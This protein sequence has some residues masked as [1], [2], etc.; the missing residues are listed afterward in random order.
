M[1]MIKKLWKYCV[2]N[3]AVFMLFPVVARDYGGANLV[4]ALIPARDYSNELSI[5]VLALPSFVLMI[6]IIYGVRKAFDWACPILVGVIFLYTFFMFYR[7]TTAVWG[8]TII[9]TAIAAVGCGFG[10][11]FHKQK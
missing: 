11:V 7:Y 2:C 5:L 4:L 6:S 9:Y 1:S 8:C 3:I 10:N